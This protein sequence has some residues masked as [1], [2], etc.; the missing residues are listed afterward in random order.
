MPEGIKSL[1]GQKPILNSVH[2]E[3]GRF[4]SHFLGVRQ[5]GIN[6]INVQPFLSP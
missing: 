3:I 6:W 5:K 4:N 2:M 1:E